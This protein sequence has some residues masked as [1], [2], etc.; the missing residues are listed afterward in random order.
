[1]TSFSER[2]DIKVSAS[3][4]R[5]LSIFAARV[6][7]F[8]VADVLQ[9][10]KETI[11]QLEIRCE[12]YSSAILKLVFNQMPRLSLLKIHLG[13]LPTSHELLVNVKPNSNVN[14]LIVCSKSEYRS[15]EVKN[16][17]NFFPKILF[18]VLKVELNS[19]SSNEVMQFVSVNLPSLQSLEI[20]NVGRVTFHNVTIPTLSKLI[21]HDYF[22]SVNQ[23]EVIAE[24]CPNIKDLVIDYDRGMHVYSKLLNDT[25]VKAVQSFKK[26][27]H[28]YMFI[29]NFRASKDFYAVLL[30]EYPQLDSLTLNESA[31]FKFK[32]WKNGKRFHL[33]EDFWH[34]VG[35]DFNVWPEEH[36]KK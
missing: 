35:T 33:L 12:K 5:K 14:T 1:M 36:L 34:N 17:I 16:I 29:E 11:Q 18:L 3:S 28:L 2:F 13:S 4:L 15:V 9:N 7:E 22:G 25:F 6:D 10:F 31:L 8:E 32:G 23:L 21:V 20:W 26:L 30:D 27:R 19:D 24:S